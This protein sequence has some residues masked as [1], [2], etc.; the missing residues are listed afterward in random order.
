MKAF[1]FPDGEGKA[2][3]GGEEQT[4]VQAYVSDYAPANLNDSRHTALVWFAALALGAGRRC[5]C[6]SPI[7]EC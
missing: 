2:D 1:C 3:G 6:E 7:T 5:R 4:A